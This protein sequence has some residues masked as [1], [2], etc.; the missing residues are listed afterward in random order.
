[1]RDAMANAVV[2]DEIYNEDPTTIKLQRDVAD[3][4]GKEAAL[5]VSSGT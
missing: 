3:L 1:M 5:I 4:L 2:G